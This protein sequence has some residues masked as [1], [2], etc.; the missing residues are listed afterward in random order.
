MANYLGGYVGN[1]PSYLG[2]YFG[3]SI[4]VVVYT[5][6]GAGTITFSGTALVSKSKRFTPSGTITFSGTGLTTKSKAYTTSGS[7]T[8][9]GT[10]TLKKTKAY[11]ASG[12]VHYT[13]TALLEKT[14]VYSGLGT[15]VF[16]GVG[17]TG[18]I[19]YFRR[20]VWVRLAPTENTVSITADLY[21]D[22]RLN[23]SRNSVTI[24]G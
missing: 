10:A 5:Y 8:F 15:I 18:Y 24:Y 2:S 17:S 16:S 9:S 7:V 6:A 13:G 23:A 12:S 4:T 14:K 19:A 22:V 20:P 1:S 11:L 21:N 3:E